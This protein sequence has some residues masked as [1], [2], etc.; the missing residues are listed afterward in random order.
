M[1]NSEVKFDFS[2]FFGSSVIYLYFNPFLENT[3]HFFCIC[4]F[5][6]ASEIFA[7]NHYSN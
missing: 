3:F 7:V 1:K 2:F 6:A 4:R 5:S